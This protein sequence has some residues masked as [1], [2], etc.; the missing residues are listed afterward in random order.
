MK[1][2]S[3]FLIS[4][5]LLSACEEEDVIKSSYND[6]LPL[7][8]G[9]TWKF[10]TINSNPNIG[11][12]FKKVI[13]TIHKN[14][15]EYYIMVSGYANPKE[16]ID[17][18]A[19]YRITP[20]GF[21]YV[22]NQGKVQEENL[23]RLNNDDGDSWSYKEPDYNDDVLIQLSEVTIHL[24]NT[25]LQQCKSFYYDVF[26]WADE[27]HTTTFAKNVGFVKTLGAWD[28]GSELASAI[29]NGKK[30]NF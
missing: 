22:M 4:L 16:T 21:V 30:L 18:I 3:V 20:D 24:E 8:I 27:E 23:F 15:L 28:M 9:N 10:N 2:L 14:G 1:Y 7:R 13:G 26:Q 29:I 5:V 12:R 17:H 19:Y 6:Y 25:S 11:Y